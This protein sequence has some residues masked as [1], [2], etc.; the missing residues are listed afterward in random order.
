MRRYFFKKL[1][2]L[3]L[4]ATG[5]K[6]FSH[7]HFYFFSTIKKIVES[8][9]RFKMP[10][11]SIG[12]RMG[13]IFDVLYSFFEGHIKNKVMY[14]RIIAFTLLMTAPQ[15][16]ALIKKMDTP[17]EEKTSETAR[18]KRV[19]S[20]V[21]LK[22]AK[23]ALGTARSYIGTPYQYGGTARSGIDCSGLVLK[24]YEKTGVLLPRTSAEMSKFGV[25]IPTKDIQIGDL[26][27]FATTGGRRVSHVAIVSNV[28]DAGAGKLKFIHASTELGVR[29]EDFDQAYYQK[30]F[31]HAMRPTQ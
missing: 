17:K 13:L 14:Y 8:V 11:P 25:F 9:C 24:A 6:N 1:Y 21:Q 5:K 22:N 3:N 10:P 16:C 30:S 7:N 19:L 12:G 4:R 29:E 23:S 28:L 27:F 31:L 20:A 15:S 26:L 18:S 2:D